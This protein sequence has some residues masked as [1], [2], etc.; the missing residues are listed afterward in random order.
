MFAK[1]IMGAAAIM[2]AALFAYFGDRLITA[3]GVAHYQSGL[4]DGQLRQVPEILAANIR[5]AR[6][7]LEARDRVIAADG[8]RD[9]ELQRLIPQM[10]SAHKKVIAY[11][12]TAAGR[13]ACLGADRVWGIER[14]RSSLFPA[15]ASDL[16]GSYAARPMQA[17]AVASPAGP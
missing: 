15:S 13:T 3:Y 11:A 7:G 6:A 14:D 16:T 4:S 2:A 12:A 8:V 5:A 17:D 10:L 9:G 1:L